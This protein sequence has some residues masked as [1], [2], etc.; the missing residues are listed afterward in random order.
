MVSILWGLEDDGKLSSW[1]HIDKRAEHES[2]VTTA[3]APGC[4]WISADLSVDVCGG[5]IAQSLP[6]QARVV[7]LVEPHLDVIYAQKHTMRHTET[8]R[9]VLE[10]SETRPEP[11]LDTGTQ[12]RKPRIAPLADCSTSLAQIWSHAGLLLTFLDL[13]T[14][15]VDLLSPRHAAGG[16]VHPDD[17]QV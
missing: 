17:L 15:Q 8:H 13:V 14:E 1:Q 16:P 9:R 12:R 7:L 6:G 11:K 2:G 4:S 5:E 10:G 3:A